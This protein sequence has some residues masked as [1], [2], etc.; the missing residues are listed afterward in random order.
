MNNAS[1]LFDSILH[2][3][4]FRTDVELAEA[5]GIEPANLS[6]LRHG[7][8]PISDGMVLR[9]HEITGW[10]IRDIKGALNMICHDQVAMPA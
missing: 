10:A 3:K 2:E 4:G 1:L 6:R 8:R 7:N 9:L 5:I